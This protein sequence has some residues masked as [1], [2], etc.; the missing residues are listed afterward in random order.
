MSEVIRKADE[1]VKEGK[2]ED[3]KEVLMQ[4]LRG[5]SQQKSF[6]QDAVS[7]FLYAQ[8]YSDAKQVFELYKDQTGKQL[9]GDFSLEEIEGLAQSE[10]VN[11]AEGYPNG[12]LFKRMSFW[13]GL[14]EG[15]S[16]L[17]F[18]PINEIRIYPDKIILYKVGVEHGYQWSEITKV[19]LTRKPVQTGDVSF[20]RKSLYLRVRK[21]VF[22]EDL[23]AFHN[24]ELLIQELKMHCC[25]V[26]EVLIKWKRLPRWFW[27]M[28]LAALF[29]TLKLSGRGLQFP[30]L[31]VWCIIIYLAGIVER[32]FLIE[33]KK[34]G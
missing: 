13:Q 10:S 32:D 18:F 1:L 9:K 20:L 31:L 12:K 4:A 8:M 19:S 33:I 21:E 25:K 34:V 6:Y 14:H 17:R 16:L 7:I 27:L 2:L 11:L 26:E 24:S 15:R 23:S 29:V 30:I 22:K 5:H 28:L 3:A